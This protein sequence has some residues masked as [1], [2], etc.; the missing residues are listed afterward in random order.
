MVV[1][2]P[3]SGST[4]LHRALADDRRAAIVEQL[5]AAGELDAAELGHRVGLHPNTVRFHLALLRDAGGVTSRP[6]GR[7]TPGR[8]RILYAL[9]PSIAHDGAQEHRLLA[10]MLAG[11]VAGLDDGP[12]RAEEAGRAWG[13]YLVKR[14]LPLA[15][16]SDDDAQAE[17][18]E[19][20]AQEG[21][22]PESAPGEIR[23]RR[24]PFYELAELHPQVVCAAHRGLIAG[25][26]DELGSGLE[27]A[28]I[29]IFPEPDVCIAHLARRSS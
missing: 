25:G 23:M 28:G 7:G 22:E 26:L 11:A 16:T 15:H 19:L 12:E 18:V 10:T 14:P 2:T 17:I 9:E 6:A 5:R 29:E 21:F 4:T 20:L 3:E 24:C 8:P 13:R 1:N 27:L